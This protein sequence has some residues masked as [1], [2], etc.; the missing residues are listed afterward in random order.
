MPELWFW[1]LASV[2]GVYIVLDGFDFGVGVLHFFL[3]R[4]ARERTTLLRTI[5]SVWDGNEVW[6]VAAGGSLFAAFPALYASTFSGFYLPL[7]IVLW[8]LIFRALGIELRHQLENPLWQRFWDVAF[9]A[10]STLLA[11]FFG[12]ALGN[13][14][15]G[16]PLDAQGDFFEPLWTDFRVGAETG[17]LDWYTLL[18]AVTALCTLSHHGALWVG[19]KTEQQLATRAARAARVLFVPTLLLGLLTTLATFAVQPQVQ[20]NLQDYPLGAALPVLALSGLLLARLRA[21]TQPFQAFLGSSAY[22]FF[23]ILSAA[24]A[25]FPHAL[26]ARDPN[27]H[28]SLRAAAASSHT[29]QLMLLWWAPGMLIAVGY[30]YYAYSR[31]PKTFSDEDSAH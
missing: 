29:L 23:Q 1:L 22:V 8:L 24:F 12:A 6:L 9:S 10:A 4:S 20:Q 5:G 2:L 16:V 3:G 18:V 11:V 15:R 26:S 30:S 28:L 21:S 19:L 13:V 14:V 27:H 31:M 17:L 25:V 7:M